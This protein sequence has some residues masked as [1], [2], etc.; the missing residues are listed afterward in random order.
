MF[1][2]GKIMFKNDV[3][4]K[5]CTKSE[6][7]EAVAKG[8]YT[9]SPDD[10]RDGFIH[11]SAFDQVTGTLDKHFKDQKGLVLLKIAVD[12]L[13]AGALKWEKSRN[14]QEFPHLYADLDPA[15]VIDK[16]VLPDHGKRGLSKDDQ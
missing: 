15:A 3:I 13:P 4:Y 7:E 9:G 16:E 8:I 10:I 2:Y 11:F 12:R 14:D 5:I 6:W 1:F